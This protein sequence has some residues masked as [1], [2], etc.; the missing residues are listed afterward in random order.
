MATHSSTLAW[1]I[2]CTEESGRLQSMG[3]QRVGHDWGVMSPR[4]GKTSSSGKEDSSEFR[5]SVSP[6]SL[7]SSW[8]SSSQ[9]TE[10]HSFSTSN[11]TS[12]VDTLQDWDFNLHCNSITY[13]FRFGVSFSEIKTLHDEEK[14]ISCRNIKCFLPS[15]LSQDERTLN[16]EM[17]FF[18]FFPLSSTG[19]QRT[20]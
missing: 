6:S 14:S 16:S 2:P 8:T 9:F 19:R 15:Y 18:F 1:R 10:N 7:E 13:R 4:S 20:P 12:R 5:G 11:L 3:S 17:I